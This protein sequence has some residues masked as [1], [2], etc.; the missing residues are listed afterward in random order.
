[1]RDQLE[2]ENCEE[3]G[4]VQLSMGGYCLN[5]DG[6]DIYNEITHDEVQGDGFNIGCIL[7]LM[8][9]ARNIST[10]ERPGIF[11]DTTLDRRQAIMTFATRLMVDSIKKRKQGTEGINS[12]EKTSMRVENH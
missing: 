12:L 3:N 5:I 9:Q 4:I 1:M 8:H 6:T 11:G 7:D 10:S 2:C